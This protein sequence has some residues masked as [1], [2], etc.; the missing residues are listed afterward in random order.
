MAAAGAGRP[1]DAALDTRIL[2]AA[3]VV[4]RGRGPEAVTVESVA[5]AAGCG[6]TSIY[7]RYRNSADILAAALAGLAD[8]AQQIHVGDTGEQGLVAA[9]EQFRVGVEQQVGLRCVASLLY[10]PESPFAQ[11]VRRH[12]LEPRL[13]AV[14]DIL[15]RSSGSDPAGPIDAETLVYALAGSYFAR[16]AVSGHVGPHW[17]RDAVQEL[18]CRPGRSDQSG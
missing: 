17:A 10:D 2:E 14:V 12:L 16:L 8:S 6:K 13:R 18:V 7:R 11:L 5:E 15:H 3:L 9:L 4:L 1:R